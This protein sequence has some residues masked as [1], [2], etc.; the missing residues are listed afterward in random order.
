MSTDNRTILVNFRIDEETRKSL[1]IWCIENNI[2]MADHLRRM[3]DDTLEGKIYAAPSEEKRKAHKK[4]A[5]LDE[6]L[7]EWQ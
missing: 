3:V 4:Q 7:K 5:E 6:F 1:R 2:S